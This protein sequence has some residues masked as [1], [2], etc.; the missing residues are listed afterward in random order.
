MT[1]ETK[2]NLCVT[3]V[4][5]LAFAAAIAVRVV[6]DETFSPGKYRRVSSRRA[7]RKQSAR[8]SVTAFLWRPSL[9]QNASLTSSQ[10]ASNRDARQF[11]F[12]AARRLRR[13]RSRPRLAEEGGAALGG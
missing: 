13:T 11:S 1:S 2:R 6:D 9:V 10:K 12:S 8:P 5:V 4:A 7:N 3:A